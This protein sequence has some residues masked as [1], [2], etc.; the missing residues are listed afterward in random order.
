[1]HAQDEEEKIKVLS[2]T[3][4]VKHNYYLPFFAFL[5]HFPLWNAKHTHLKVLYNMQGGG[6]P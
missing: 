3:D 4:N 6:S 5:S 1:M 2:T